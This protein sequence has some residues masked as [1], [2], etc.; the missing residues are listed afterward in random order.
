MSSSEIPAKFGPGNAY[1]GGRLAKPRIDK[2]PET[3]AE[4]RAL[5]FMIL[6][7][8]TTKK[9]IV[10]LRRKCARGNVGTLEFLFDR[11]IGRPAVNVHHDADASLM[12]FVN[13]WQQLVTDAKL[14]Q[15]PPLALDAAREVIDADFVAT[16][17]DDDDDDDETG[18]E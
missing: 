16:A 4:I 12:N 3:P 9:M 2:A 13:A 10:S 8:E 17:D 6:D 11:L 5:L 18:N 1:N 7:E 15:A 14:E